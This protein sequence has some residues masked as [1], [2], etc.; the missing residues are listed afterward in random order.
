M[1]KADVART[2]AETPL[3]AGLDPAAVEA[4]AEQ[5]SVRTFSKGLHLFHQGVLRVMPST[6]SRKAG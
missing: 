6:S 2:L 3:F 1:A 5:A 4:I